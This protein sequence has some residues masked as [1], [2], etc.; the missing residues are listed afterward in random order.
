MRSIWL[1]TVC[2][3]SSLIACGP[4]REGFNGR[5]VPTGRTDATVRMDVPTGSC[6]AGATFCS[7]SCVSVQTSNLHCGRCGNMCQNGQTCNAGMCTGMV[8]MCPAGQMSCGGRCVNVQTDAANCGRCGTMCPGGQTCQAGACRP[9]G[10]CAAPMMTCSGV[11]IDPQTDSNNCG[12]CGTRCAAG[13][14]CV[15]GRCTGGG[16]MMCIDPCA[17]HEQ[18]QTT[19]GAPPAGMVFCCSAGAGGGGG[20]CFTMAG[21]SCGG[22]GGGGDGGLGGGDGGGGLLCLIGLQPCANNGDCMRSCAGIAET[23]NGGTCE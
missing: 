18:C 19:C 5:D 4:D 14:N 21:A 22:G 8:V 6:P 10:A 17:S 9:A 12:A 16:G 2:A 7:G 13:Q 20:A 11:C 1:V 23:C 3:L 15:A